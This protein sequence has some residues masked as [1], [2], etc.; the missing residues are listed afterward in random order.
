MRA[1]RAALGQSWAVR[2]IGGGSNLLPSDDGVEGLVI[3]YTAAGHQLREDGQ[4]AVCVAEAGASLAGL[5]RRLAKQGWAGLE[6]AVSVPGTVGGAAVNNAGAFG[7]CSAEWIIAVHVADADGQERRLG[8][9]ALDYAYR[10]SR[11]K[12]RELGPV[13]VLRVEFDLRRDDPARLRAIV[14]RNQEQRTRTQPR[15][16][17]AGSVFANPEGDYAGRLIEQAGLKGARHGGAQISP[18]H[19]NFIVNSGRATARDVYELMRLAQQGVWQHFATW[20]HPEIELVGRWMAAELSALAGP[21]VTWN[22]AE[23]PS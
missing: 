4:R 16:R 2:T 15:Q 13:I 5:A 1:L 9:A 11:L 18:Q 14:D 7:S 20:L 8:A 3:K 22:N 21:T 6:W 12:R 10:T 17:S 23:V 19:A